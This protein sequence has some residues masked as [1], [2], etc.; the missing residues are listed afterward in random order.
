MKNI[1]FIA[2]FLFS[3]HASDIEEV[4]V[5]EHYHVLDANVSDKDFWDKVK[6][7]MQKAIKDE[8]ES[9]RGAIIK[10]DTGVIEFKKFP[11]KKG[12]GKKSAHKFDKMT[13]KNIAWVELHSRLQP[14]LRDLAMRLEEHFYSKKMWK[15]HKKE[16]K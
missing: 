15:K 3:G 9:C 11:P 14:A 6:E 10:T 5:E 12:H 13:A 16:D 4:K 7:V 2:F 1:L 8:S